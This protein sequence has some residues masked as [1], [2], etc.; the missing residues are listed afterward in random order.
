[1]ANSIKRFS[2]YNYAF[3]N[4]MRFIDPDGMSPTNWVENKKRV[5]LSGIQ[6]LITKQM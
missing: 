5:K 4:P 6:T 2:P 3:D 1:M